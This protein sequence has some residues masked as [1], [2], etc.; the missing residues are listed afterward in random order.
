MLS[1]FQIHTLIIFLLHCI[2][3][4]SQ[5]IKTDELETIVIEAN[6]REQLIPVQ[7]L[8]GKDLERLNSH[9]VA[10]ALRYFSG[11]KI[12]D[13]GGIGGLKTVDVRN[14]GTHHVGVM[15]NGMQIGNA[16]NGI[17]DLGKFSLDD[18]E[19]IT[20]YNGERN[21]IFQS[22]KEFASASNIYINAKKPHF[23]KEK[24]NNATIRF[25]T[26]SI[27]LFNPSFRVEKQLTPNIRTSLSSEYI[28]SNGRYKFRQKKHNL[29]GSVAYDTTAYRT[30]SDIEAWRIENG[31]FGETPKG[32]WEANLYFYNSERGLPEAFIKKSQETM[33]TEQKLERLWDKNFFAQ[34]SWTHSPFDKYQFQI[35]GK[36]AYDYTRYLA[37][38]TVV[39][40]DELVT[41]NL[42]ADNSFFQQDY[43]LSIA[44]HYDITTNWD[45]AV[46]TDLQYNK[47]NASRKGIQTPFSY[48]ERL[49][50]LTSIA[51]SVNFGKFKAQ[52]HLLGTFTQENVKNNQKAPDRSLFTPS[53]VISYSPFY[54]KKFTIHSFYKNTYR[55]PTFNDLYYTNLGDANLKPESTNQ[56]NLGF[57]YQT[58]TE[59]TWLNT[60]KIKVESYYAKVENKIIATPTSSMFRWMMTNLGKVE[61]YGLETN[62]ST[63]S[64][65]GK[66]FLNTNFS[67]EYTLASDLSTTSSGKTTSY[68]DQIPYTPWHSGSAIASLDYEKWSLNYSFIYV[69]KR[70]NGN[71]NNIKRNEIQPWYTHDLSINRTI[72]WKKHT[73]KVSIEANNLLN[74]YYD[75][76]TNFPM[77]GRNFRFIL[78]IEL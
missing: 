16:Q 37:R 45:V 76:V 24:K 11:I 30:N 22:A 14:M 55:L 51:S 56:I 2:S 27:Q 74:Q 64:K 53:L 43:Y 38:N 49:S 10:D 35:K 25:K 34:S 12:K 59:H 9:S 19:S 36:F 28:K 20:L 1:K 75:V 63:Q 26:A 70:Y 60:W 72:N 78:S 6:Q 7:K 62:F 48:P 57:Q 18:V 68:G 61:N 40:D 3:V 17:V 13:Y 21:T 71:K 66:L 5:E 46:A 44:H 8:S 50:F 4:H 47:L 54:Q 69:G 73:L 23:D 58:Q 29:D 65:L 42:Q 15:Y 33:E 32:K 39:F 77:P 41:Q 52:A 31:W 67:Y